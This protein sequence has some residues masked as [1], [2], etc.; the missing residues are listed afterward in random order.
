MKTINIYCYF[1][2][3]S[4]WIQVN[5]TLKWHIEGEIIEKPSFEEIKYNQE[6]INSVDKSAFSTTL[7]NAVIFIGVLCILIGV[8]IR[9]LH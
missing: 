5:K 9:F 3:K 4:V 6:I 8:L 2:R 7:S 1:N